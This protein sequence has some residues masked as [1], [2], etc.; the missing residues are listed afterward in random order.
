[1]PSQFSEAVDFVTLG[2]HVSNAL[3]T[4]MS[5]PHRHDEIEITVLA[6][7]WIDYLFGG[8]RV[9]NQAGEFCVRWAAIPHQSIDFE[10]GGIHYSL[11]IPLAWFLSWRLPESL[12]NRLMGGEMLIESEP[13]VGCA[14]LAMM[15]RWHA[16]FVA[17][18]A[19]SH[20]MILLEAEA[21][22]L[23]LALR[24]PVANTPGTCVGVQGQLGKFER[25]T[26]Y[27]AGHYTGDLDVSTI[28][29]V[30]GMHPNSAMRLFRETCGLTIHEYLTMHRIWHAQHLLTTTTS[31]IR[32][33][34]E[35]C[36]F[37]TPNRFYAAFRRIVGKLPG[38][39]RQSLSPAD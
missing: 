32:D 11:K 36:G 27:I 22:L 8:R 5:K 39:F 17:N 16:A 38:D 12:V 37:R 31:K 13:D 30:V 35:A 2:F 3:T 28:A 21:R 33:V 9:R 14:D 26:V 29:G 18:T 1:M 34:S 20:R 7:G 10:P 6:A 23:R 15:R 4:R 19:E 25:M 24:Q